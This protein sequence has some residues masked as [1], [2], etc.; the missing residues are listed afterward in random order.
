MK[1]VRSEKSKIRIFLSQYLLAF[2]LIIGSILRFYNA[3]NRYSLGDESIRD[4]IVA[5]VGAAYLQLPLTGPF[6]SAGP[7]TFG[8]WYWYHLI[9]FT[10]LVPIAFSP[11]IL[12]GIFSTVTIFVYYKIGEALI[13]K[14]CGLLMAFIVAISPAHIN[15]AF[16]L[17]NPNMIHL[18]VAL[19]FYL[20]IRS[21]KEKM[22][23]WLYFLFGLVLG[24]GAN[25]HYQMLL[26]F[27][28]PSLGVFFKKNDRINFLLLTAFGVIISF[29]PLLFFNV[30][31]QWY[32]LRN[33][34]D[35][36][37]LNKRNIQIP[38]RWLFYIRDFWPRLFSEVF[39]LPH[40][41]AIFLLLVTACGSLHLLFKKKLSVLYYPLIILFFIIFFYLRFYSREKF[42][43][44]MHFLHPLLFIFV[45]STIYL[46]VR[47]M[48][49]KYIILGV[50][51]VAFAFFTF[52]KN[53]ASMGADTFNA[54]ARGR[55]ITIENAYPAGY[56][57]YRCISDS[58]EPY[59]SF[60]SSSFFL[61]DAQGALDDPKTKLGF[62]SPKC[63][64]HNKELLRL[65][66]R[67]KH[68]RKPLVKNILDLTSLSDKDINASGYG[69]VDKKERFE[70]YVYWWKKQKPM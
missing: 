50:I 32:T 64:T 19:T 11:W 66:E 54:D 1:N 55:N 16:G 21:I 43:G 26:L 12:L 40:V 58:S 31:N 33:F 48:K 67:G 60:V 24:I 30:N 29:L 20:F 45:A 8:P 14:E 57:V 2:I 4:A 6:S 15:S 38:Y 3:P 10:M 9:V 23:Y 18:Y 13:N 51:V 63:E 28:L 41:L 61:L 62:L 49:Q 56:E 27:A 36:S 68:A 22:P 59:V 34:I 42:F 39:G 25:I 46:L 35:Y 37:I 69:K 17:T 70:T 47:D 44:Y 65:L 53:I 7:F 52:P 5:S